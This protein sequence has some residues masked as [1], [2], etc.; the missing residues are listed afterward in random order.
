VVHAA[1]SRTNAA[2]ASETA[3]VQVRKRFIVF[4]IQVN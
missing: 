1:G 4:S 2:A 3:V